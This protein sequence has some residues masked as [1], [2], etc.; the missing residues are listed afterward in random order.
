[1]PSSDLLASTL[2][3][4]MSF[5]T[6]MAKIYV[7]EKKNMWYVHEAIIC[8]KSEYF[9]KALQGGFKEGQQKEVYLEEV[10]IDAFSL[11][12]HWTYGNDRLFQYTK[13]TEEDIRTRR[14]RPAV[15]KEAFLYVK[16]YHLA[17]YLG[18]EDLENLAMDVIRFAL[19][20]SRAQT[21]SST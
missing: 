21:A 13:R 3:N 6:S 15:E 9:S 5:S 4:L 8:A 17:N 14:I 19:L 7:G 1:M 12:M 10:D 2:F 11:S 18:I 20:Q 16:V